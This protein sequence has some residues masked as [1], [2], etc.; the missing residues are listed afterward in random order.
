[1]GAQEHH[2]AGLSAADGLPNP[3]GMRPQQSVLELLQVAP[4]DPHLR[5]SAKARVDTVGGRSVIGEM[6]FHHRSCPLHL[7]AA[8]G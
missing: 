7:S 4:L 3:H 8:L 1:M 5:Q 6:L 2:R